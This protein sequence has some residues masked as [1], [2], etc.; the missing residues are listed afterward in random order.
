MTM[1]TTDFAL[2]GAAPAFAEP[3]PTGQ[4][5]F[6]SWESYQE[7]FRGIFERQYYT[8]YGPLNQQL[9]QKLQ[10]FLGVKH[11][12]CVTNETI[13]MMMLADAMGLTGKV[14]LPAFA[15]IAPAQSLSWAGLEPVFCDVN[16]G[17]HQLDLELVA[18]LI[19]ED[20]S[21]IMGVHLWG[22]ACAPKALAELA[23]SHEVQLYF[24]AAH[25][26]GCAVDGVCVGNF[27]RAEVFSFHENNILNATEG[28]C[29]C[30][31]DDEL[32][33]RL[34]TMRSSAGAGKPVEVIKTVNGRMSEAQAAITLMNLENFPAN[35]Q[36]NR[37]LY[38]LYEARLKTIPGLH[39][40]KPSGVSFSNYQYM[41]CQ[42]DES[43]FG[44][45]RDVLMALLRAEN[46]VAQRYFYPG[47]HRSLP[48]V[49]EL[50]QY[51]D[52][53]PNTDR[54]SASC[55]QLPIG[56]LVSAQS[57]ER[58]LNIL[59]RAHHAAAAISGRY[60]HSGAVG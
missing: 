42:V 50:P 5:Y 14:I 21:A 52:R 43:E 15:F 22:G 12:I 45:S 34:R 40:V 30:T 41:V 57:V 9:E 6:P 36:N 32:A 51:L 49:Q 48:Y 24:D 54:L 27:G 13:A 11:A 60:E 20:V 33:A 16:P 4:L 37:N 59:G 26:F 25:A 7:A 39:L 23:K 55:I 1:S 31:N 17:T 38:H 10:Q 35:Q 56:A 46:V 47:L 28:G 53:L 44:M 2:F 3:L 29:I 58:I 19:D 8:E 18:S